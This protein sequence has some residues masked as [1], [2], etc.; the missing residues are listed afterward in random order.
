MSLVG[1]R[2][3]RPEFVRQLCGIPQYDERHAVRPGI[4]G[5][6]QIKFRYG[7]TFEHARR[8]L[9]YDLYY[10]KNSS[11]RMDLAIMVRTIKIVLLG[12]RHR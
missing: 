6:A 3:E 11:L 2:P 7:A 5:W 9:E 4:T 1:P 12:W 8:K 10:L